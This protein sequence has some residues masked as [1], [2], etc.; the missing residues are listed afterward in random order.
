MVGGTVIEVIT[1]EDRI[2]INC[3]DS[4][5]GRK[6]ECAIYV[7]RN[8]HSEAIRAG[9]VVWWQS[10]HAMWTPI[11]ADLRGFEDIKIPRIG[12]SGVPRPEA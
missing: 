3:R 6:D 5:Q 7:E 10:Q 2:W 12:Y 11:S 4:N 1:L 9:D 8:A